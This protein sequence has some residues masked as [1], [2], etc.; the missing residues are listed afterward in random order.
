MRGAV[1]EGA[2]S[3][4][5]SQ[6]LRSLPFRGNYIP[7]KAMT[8][9]SPAVEIEAALTP[10]SLAGFEDLLRAWVRENSEALEQGGL[11]RSADLAQSCL[12][13]FRTGRC[14]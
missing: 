6:K 7:D 3:I 2:D 14:S 4:G 5:V 8:D 9:S 10:R 13:W 1:F 12:A 11:G